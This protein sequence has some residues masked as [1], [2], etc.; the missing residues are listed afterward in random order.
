MLGA[1]NIDGELAKIGREMVE[2]PLDPCLSKILIPS[3]EF[4]CSAKI[5]IIVSMLSVPN[6][7]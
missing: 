3:I 1:L 5:L 4:E 2:F 6:V 7:F